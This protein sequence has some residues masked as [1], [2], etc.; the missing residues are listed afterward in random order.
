MADKR[1]TIK[2][3]SRAGKLGTLLIIYGIVIFTC[4]W[5]VPDDKNN[6]AFYIIGFITVLVGIA[7]PALLSSKD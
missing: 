3:G 1:K 2:K 4:A 6:S 7:A 5:W